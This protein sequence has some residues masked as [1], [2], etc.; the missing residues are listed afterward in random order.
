MTT[1]KPNITVQVDLTN[2]G[3]FFACCGLF[4]LA[5]RLWP[6]AEAWFDEDTFCIACTGEMTRL[7]QSLIDSE[8]RSSVGDEGLR[9]LG[10]LMSAKKS[11]LSDQD[12]REKESLRAM[13]QAESLVLGAPFNIVLNWWRDEY[14][15]R[16]ALKTWAAKQ[17]IV[18]IVRPLR[19]AVAEISKVPPFDD[20][21]QRAVEVDGLP[22]FF[23]SHTQCQ[24]TALD[25]GFSTYDLRRVIKESPSTR[26]ALEFFAFVGMQRFRLLP[27]RVDGTFVFHTWH[28]PFSPPVA[29]VAAMGV[30]R[31][32]GARSYQFRLLDRTKYMK[33][34]LPA[35]PVGDI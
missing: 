13:W 1:T 33:A 2:P 19:S 12:Q 7:L 26:P 35:T 21:F 11:S 20:I 28:T 30:L 18:D 6:G 9:R 23:D 8:L 10:T 5:D 24:S 3:Q 4:E 31:S 25:A 29:A 14:N 17:F 16:T 22:L 15:N 34:F 32:P 27:R